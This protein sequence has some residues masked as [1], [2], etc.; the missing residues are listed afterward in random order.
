MNV[1]S[2][3]TID[4]SVVLGQ[5]LMPI[6]QLLRMGRGAVIELDT[7]DEDDVIIMANG[8]PIARGKI[9]IQNGKIA[10]SLTEVAINPEN[11]HAQ[12]S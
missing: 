7:K 5:K 12:P 9:I 2:S 6:K 3:I 8:K 10:V 11:T 4:L 1:V